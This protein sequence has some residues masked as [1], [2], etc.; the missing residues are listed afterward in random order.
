MSK[1]TKKILGA[2]L[3]LAAFS[4]GYAQNVQAQSCV[5]LPTCEELGYTDIAARCENGELLKCPFDESKVFCRSAPTTKVCDTIGDILLDDKTCIAA[6]DSDNIPSDRTPIGVIFD[7]SRKLAIALEDSG[8][9]KWASR[10]DDD[11]AELTNYQSSKK[12]SDFSGRSNTSIIIAHGNSN[13]YDTPAADYAYN[14]STTGT[15]Q[16]DWYLPAAGEVKLI[17]DNKDIL[18]KSLSQLGGTEL[19]TSYC[20]SSTECSDKGRVWA[21]Y[22]QN[23]YWTNYLKTGSKGYVRPV[24]S[25]NT[26]CTPN[27]CS[28]YTLSSCPANGNCSTCDKVN[29]DCSNGG[30]K[31]KL[32]SCASGYE[33]SGNECK[34]ICIPDEDETGCRYGTYSC[35][36]GCGG[37][38]ICCDIPDCPTGT[39]WNTKQQCCIR[40]T[41]YPSGNLRC[42]CY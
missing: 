20:W 39:R 12:T 17:Y 4:F 28:G 5:V 2:S 22:V 29:D 19:G 3:S 24:I 8:Y 36:D 27:A 13:G 42:P 35:S 33:I 10:Y 26:S 41:C 6:A 9:L 18:N 11:I 25:F 16:G 40:T 38:R 14:Y 15:Q 23:D 30:K 37:T 21:F 1:I 32:D 31:Y 34:K 7:V